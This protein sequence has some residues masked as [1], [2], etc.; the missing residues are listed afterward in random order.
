MQLGF[1]SWPGNFHA[2]WFGKTNNNNNNKKLSYLFPS[3]EEQQ[4]WGGN[5]LR[6]RRCLSEPHS[7]EL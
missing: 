6:A 1:D 2:L 4:G 7:S 3:L 5:I